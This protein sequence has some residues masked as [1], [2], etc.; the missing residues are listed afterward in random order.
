M[1]TLF[2]AATQQAN[3]RYLRLLAIMGLL[4]TP[5]PALLGALV[6]NGRTAWHQLG[7][8]TL[9]IITDLI[10]LRVMTALR[11]RPRIPTVVVLAGNAIGSGAATAMGFAFGGPMALLV[12][13]GFFL[14][15]S[16]T[17]PLV[18]SPPERFATVLMMGA[19]I[20]LG[21]LLE[22]PSRLDR[23]MLLSAS[24]LLVVSL[25]FSFTIGWSATALAER[26]YC[27]QRRLTA[28]ADSTAAELRKLATR[29]DELREEDR[30]HIAREGT[31]FDYT[32][33]EGVTEPG[34]WPRLTGLA[35]AVPMAAFNPSRAV[36]IA[37]GSALR[38]PVAMTSNR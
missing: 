15:I 14:I 33:V 18:L 32:I 19:F 11:H 7:W 31:G 3:E 37:P 30:T 23:P 26:T 12:V 20:L 34:R 4:I 21:F 35:R 1:Y 24:G 17:I 9:M 28:A 2:Y 36:W 25:A 6:Y 10:G 13:A 29:I 22:F 16:L 27:E 5:G 8:H 38:S